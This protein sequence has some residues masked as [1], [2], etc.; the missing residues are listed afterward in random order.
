MEYAIAIDIGGT[1]IKYALVSRTGEIV[2]ESLKSSKREKRTVDLLDLLKDIIYEIQEIALSGNC[3]LFG[4]GIGVP[5]IV[6]DGTI[7]FANNLPALNNRNL[8]SLLEPSVQIP[9]WVDNDANLMGLG[10]VIYGN[11]KNLTDV[12]FLTIGTGIGGA[13]VLDGCLYSGFRNRGAE[14]GHIIIEQHGK[15]CSCGAKGCFEAYA[16][17]SALIDDY[18]GFLIADGQPL[19]TDVDGK[20]IIDKYHGHQEAAVKAMEHHFHAMAAGVTSL[21]HVFAPQ[22]VIIGGGISEAG[23]FYIE[24][25]R[26]RVDKMVMKET[27]CFTTIEQASLGNKAGFLEASAMVFQSKK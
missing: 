14:L 8:I 12:V 13:L 18:K 5:S 17:V 4:V 24:N 21:I 10:E 6:D 3:P 22:K 7:L 1:N 27:S 19:T 26:K 23:D 11:V 2:Y 16:S 15:P 25:I 20:Y 9:V